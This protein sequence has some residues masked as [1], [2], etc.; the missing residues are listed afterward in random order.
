LGLINDSALRD[1]CVD[2]KVDDE[3]SAEDQAGQGMQ[4]AQEKMMMASEERG[5]QICGC[6]SR[7]R[8]NPFAGW[9][10]L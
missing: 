10:R 7:H 5:G 9:N 6:R 3:I 4:P 1:R 2:E 8:M